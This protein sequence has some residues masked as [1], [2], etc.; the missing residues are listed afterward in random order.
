MSSPPADP[1]SRASLAR[2]LLTL[3]GPIALGFLGTNLM[4]IVDTAM[5]R[6]LGHVAVGAVGLGGAVYGF[7]LLSG[8]GLLLGVDRVAAVALGAGRRDDVARALVGGVAI[9]L[10]A[11]VPLAL[12][13]R[14]ASGYVGHFGVAPELVPITS[15]YLRTLAPAVVPALLFFAARQTLQAV[16]DTTAATGILFATNGLNALVGYALVNG[17]LGM[18][19]LGAPGVALATLTSQTVMALSLFA[20]CARR[21][22]G[23]RRVG[24]RPDLATLRELLR[25]GLPAS[26]QLVLEVGVFSFVALLAA[27]IDAVSAAAHQAVIQIASFTFMVPLGLSIAGA[28]RVG[29][30]IGRE[31]YARA[32]RIGTTAVT[33]G[34][35]FMVASGLTLT[36]AWR[37]ILGVFVTDPQVLA[38]ARKLLA[39]AAVFQLFDGMQ[40]TLS[41]A[42][43]GAGDTTSSMFANLAG[44]WALGLPVGCALAF[45]YHLGALGL[46]VGLAVGLGSVAMFLLARWRVRSARMGAP[47]P[48]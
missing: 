18:P 14:V 43:R 24:L 37:P 13:L 42:L 26:L 35:L 12:G 45:W 22:L 6:P 7:A 19:R 2:D 41:G 1:G 28:V 30:S 31:D 32:R 16:D 11:G 8:V 27:R 38:L 34:A 21:G 29:Q 33:L 10:C 17:R 47:A 36:L 44:H 48:R 5:V 46:W 20:W 40:V 23:V 4:T 9:A 3:A 25:L 15:D 39:V